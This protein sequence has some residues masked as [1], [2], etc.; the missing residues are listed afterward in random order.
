MASQKALEIAARAWGKP[1]AA[2]K[3]MDGQ[4]AHAFADVIDDLL[5]TAELP[6]PPVAVDPALAPERALAG[7]AIDLILAEIKA[8]L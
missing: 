4:L 3:V 7:V 1:A 8:R 2:G 6:A 5:A